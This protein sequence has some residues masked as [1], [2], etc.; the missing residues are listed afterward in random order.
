M[1]D[2]EE[3]RGGPCGR[4]DALS[5][6]TGNEQPIDFAP[7]PRLLPS[8]TQ[9]EHQ[10]QFVKLIITFFVLYHLVIT[11]IPGISR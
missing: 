11:N 4:T 3:R 1:P 9:K 5:D 8:R 6:T 7:T 10:W 2:G